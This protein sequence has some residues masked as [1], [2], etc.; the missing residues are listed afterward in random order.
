MLTTKYAEETDFI[1]EFLSYYLLSL[2]ILLPISHNKL[3]FSTL[4][5]ESKRCASQRV[6]HCSIYNLI[7]RICDFVNNLMLSPLS[8]RKS[9]KTFSLSII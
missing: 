4:N 6:H 9:I 3:Y 8:T 1:F 5:Y 7:N 2:T